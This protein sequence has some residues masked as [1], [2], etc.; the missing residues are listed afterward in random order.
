MVQLLIALSIVALAA[1]L[2]EVLRRRRRVDP[3]TQRPTQLPGQ[4][5]RHDFE[6]PEAPWLVA[7][8]TSDTCSTC[9]DVITK[10]KVLE[11]DAVAVTVVSYQRQRAL[12]DR[13]RIDAVPGVVIVDSHGVAHATFL[14]PITATDLWAAVADAREPGSRPDPMCD[15]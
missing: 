4:L 11:S 1:V 14:G 10:A 7:V 2:A 3:P 5:D 12:H 8:F 9:A 13:Y 6:R 15:R